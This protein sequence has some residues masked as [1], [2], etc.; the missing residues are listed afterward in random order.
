[1]KNCLNC[2]T[3]FDENILY[4]TSK[5]KKFCSVVCGTR[6]RARIYHHK[7]ENK[8]NLW[9]KLNKERYNELIKKSYCKNKEKWHS[10]VITKKVIQQLRNIE[11]ILPRE[12]KE[13]HDNSNIEIHH[14]IY[15]PKQLQ[16]LDGIFDEKIYYLCKKCHGKSSRKI[17]K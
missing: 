11:K 3:E 13:C 9:S 6:Y 17:Y 2:N 5:K 12:C 1:M 16:I 10:R 4:G 7:N 8:N 15:P 14:E